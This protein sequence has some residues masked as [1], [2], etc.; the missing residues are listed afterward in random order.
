M[1]LSRDD[2]LQADDRTLQE[3]EVPQWGGTLYVRELSAKE[4]EDFQSEA[5]ELQEMAEEGEDLP[6]SWRAALVALCAAD[7]DGERMFE[8]EDRE[9]LGERSNDAIDLVANVALEVNGIDLSEEGEE[10][11]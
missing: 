2:V 1:A 11:N 9:A 4:V 3:V 6:Y 5:A 7:E 8:P 10:G